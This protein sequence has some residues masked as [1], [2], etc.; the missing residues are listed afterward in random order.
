[1]AA[2]RMMRREKKRERLQRRSQRIELSKQLKDPSL[3]IEQKF[4][5]LATLEKMPR[6]SS[7]VRLMRRCQRTGRAHGV[8]RKF[9]LCRNEIRVRAML[10]EIPGLVKAS[11]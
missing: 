1:M 7:S 6:D 9:G 8:Y 3:D 2:K 11:W 4:K 5:I 10:G